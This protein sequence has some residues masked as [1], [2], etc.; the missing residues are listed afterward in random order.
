VGS[1]GSTVFDWKNFGIECGTCF[2]SVPHKVHFLAGPIHA[3]FVPKEKRKI[4]RKPKVVDEAEEETAEDVKQ[5]K[6][7]NKDANTLSA[8]QKQMKELVKVLYKRCKEEK[9]STIEKLQ[10]VGNELPTEEAK[11]AAR[12]QAE[13]HGD[14]VC[15]VKF[16]FN[17]KSF[18]QTV[19]NIFS[20]SF[21][22]KE[23]SAEAGV[24]DQKECDKHHWD[25]SVLPGPWIRSLKDEVTVNTSTT[26]ENRQAIVRLNMKVCVGL[27]SFLSLSFRS[28][29]VLSL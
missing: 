7:G 9:E 21:L 22:V 3:A 19:E 4:V 15:A 18:T 12:K 10:A 28:Y 20:L 16:L 13:K 27:G 23:G 25:E 24:R 11:T 1:S 6:G 29:Y 26:I 2:N 14:R 8:S 17:P 5:A